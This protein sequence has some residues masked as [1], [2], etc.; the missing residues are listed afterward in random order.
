MKHTSGPWI[1]VGG[2]V[3]VEN[4][5]IPDICTCN[6]HDFGQAHLKRNVLEVLSNARLIAASPQMLAA[7]NQITLLAEW[8]TTGPGKCGS[9]SLTAKQATSL[10]LSISNLAR[11]AIL[12]AT[13]E[14]A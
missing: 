11:E 8:Q 2:L 12:M 1:A 10:R 4:D 7:L 13:G 5:N 3:E 9:G 14:P 6:P